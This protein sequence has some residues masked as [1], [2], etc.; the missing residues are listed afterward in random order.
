MEPTSDPNHPLN[1]YPWQHP[2]SRERKAI[3]QFLWLAREKINEPDNQPGDTAPLPFPA[4]E[5][6]RVL[7]WLDARVKLKSPLSQG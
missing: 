1:Q 3:E 5:G 6:R 7:D 2:R 4:E